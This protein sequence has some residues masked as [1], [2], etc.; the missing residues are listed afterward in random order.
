MK[1]QYLKLTPLITFIVN[2]PKFFSK[3]HQNTTFHFY[4]LL[5]IL[6][7][8]IKIFDVFLTKKCI[9]FNKYHELI[10]KKVKTI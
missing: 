6:F 5:L 8:Y 10:K 9:D 4:N 7:I 3:F 2:S 1:P